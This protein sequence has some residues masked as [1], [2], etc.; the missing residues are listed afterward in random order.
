VHR[1]AR[2]M[3]PEAFD[4]W[5]ARLKI[6]YRVLLDRTDTNSTAI[7]RHDQVAEQMTDLVNS[8]EKL[9]GEHDAL[10]NQVLGQPRD[11][12]DHDCSISSAIAQL[13]N[14]D[15]LQNREIGSLADIMGNWRD[16]MKAEIAVQKE[17]SAT[18]IQDLT[19]QVDRFV[20]GRNSEGRH[21]SIDYRSRVS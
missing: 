21:R 13:R 16:E 15:M 1:S 20:H 12:V 10:G 18:K 2:T 11:F 17:A 4:L 3:T 7:A 5:R 19:L 6:E 14:K 8:L 9:K